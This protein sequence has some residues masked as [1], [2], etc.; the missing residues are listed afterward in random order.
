MHS[1]EKYIKT[2]MVNSLLDH[3]DR[4]SDEENFEG[5]IV[6]TYILFTA[7]LPIMVTNIGIILGI[8]F[9]IIS[10]TM[11]NPLNF[12]IP[13]SKGGLN[14]KIARMA[15]DITFTYLFYKVTFSS[16]KLL[17]SRTLGLKAYSFVNLLLFI[18]IVLLFNGGINTVRRSNILAIHILL[19]IKILHDHFYVYEDRVDNFII[20]IISFYAINPLCFIIF[21]INRRLKV[22]HR[23]NM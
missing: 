6:F 1:S 10:F 2:K 15:L 23:N 21:S 8:I 3:Y 14:V 13:F 19:H 16:K 20:K 17:R 18:S 11:I 5:K 12:A 7:M 4:R 22:A 9:G